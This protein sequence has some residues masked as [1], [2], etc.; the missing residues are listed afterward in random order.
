M[1]LNVA[2]SLPAYLYKLFTN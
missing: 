2:N 1:Q